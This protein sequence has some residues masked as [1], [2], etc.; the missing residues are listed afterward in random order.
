MHI[1]PVDMYIT[2]VKNSFG[3]YEFSLMALVVPLKVK[4]VEGI[5]E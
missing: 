2:A 3:L 4:H 1:Y 5:G